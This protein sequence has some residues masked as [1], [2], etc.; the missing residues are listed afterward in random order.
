MDKL[1]KLNPYN[2]YNNMKDKKKK[3]FKFM[4]KSEQVTRCLQRRKQELISLFDSKCCLCGF[5]QFQE[6]L[7]FH[8]VFPH[9]KEF[10]LS[11]GS[12]RSLEKQLEEAKKCILV[13]SNCHRG[14]HAGKLEVPDNWET[15]YNINH[16]RQLLEEKNTVKK[17][18]CIICGK[19]ITRGAEMCPACYRTKARTVERPS[20]ENLKNLIRTT[21]FTT[22]GKKY[23]VSD[24][25]IRKWC[26]AMNL[27]YKV[28]EIKKYTDEEWVKI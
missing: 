10:N 15:F 3:E 11:G 8:H 9:L 5:N 23:N 13:C 25:T 19:E 17:Y 7:E 24:N 12:A 27:P 21:A 20:R 22:I 1:V 28:S 6:A 14:I 2:F 16:A 18:Y 26:K 4:N